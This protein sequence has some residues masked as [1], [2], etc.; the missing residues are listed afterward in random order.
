MGC[1]F[2]S[3]TVAPE[4]AA[5][6]LPLPLSG[7]PGK[8]A[9]FGSYCFLLLRK[10]EEKSDYLRLCNANIDFSS[11]T[12]EWPEDY[13]LAGLALR[14]STHSRFIGNEVRGRKGCAHLPDMSW[15]TLK[16]PNVSATMQLLVIF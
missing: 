5:F 4:A 15:R 11:S 2:S 10:V 16:S 3:G 12:S 13:L 8:L 1:P 9:L 6:L 14:I 7:S